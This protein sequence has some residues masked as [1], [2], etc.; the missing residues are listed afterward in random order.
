MGGSGE[1]R[2]LTAAEVAERV[3]VHRSTVVRGADAGVGPRPIRF[4]MRGRRSGPVRVDPA[5]VEEWLR[6]SGLPEVG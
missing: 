6:R 1:R 5:D 3:Q 4:G 2:L